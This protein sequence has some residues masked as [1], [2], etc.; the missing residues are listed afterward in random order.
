LQKAVQSEQIGCI[1]ANN[2]FSVRPLI[3]CADLQRLGC[4][5][6]AEAYNRIQLPGLSLE[7]AEMFMLAE[8]AALYYEQNLTQDQIAK[9]MGLSRSHVSRLLKESRERGVVEIKV[10]HPLRVETELQQELIARLGL[11]DALVLAQPERAEE[12]D[13]HVGLL[14]A[15]Y[16]LKVSQPGNVIGV[17][18]GR[19]VKWTVDQ[20][21]SGHNYGGSVVQLMGSIVSGDTPDMNGPEIANRLAQALSATPYYLHSPL[22]VSD[23]AVRNSLIADPHLQKSLQKAREAILALISVGGVGD[24]SGIYRA[25]YISAQTLAGY[26]E[27]GAVA[28]VCGTYVTQDG[29][30]LQFDINERMISIESDT[31]RAIPM[32]IGVSFGLP[33]ARPNL[34]AVRAGLINVLIT[35]AASAKALLKILNE[36]ASEKVA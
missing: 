16:L 28:E 10:K 14:A 29:R 18:W 9:V 4:F 2:E 23:L 15:R 1:L 13:Q 32:R 33:K 31:L 30:V 20:L 22:I 6:D 12:V 17:G 26:R 8:I 27:Q 19:G 3:K 21:S 7:D 36:E 25:G 35:D 24:T 11:K 34:G 5:M